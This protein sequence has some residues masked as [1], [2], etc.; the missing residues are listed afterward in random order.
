MKTILWVKE[1]R[2]IWYVVLGSAFIGLGISLFINQQKLY[3]GGINGLTQL[4]VNI[5][6]LIS[7]GEIV[8][9]LGI[10]AFVL[11]MPLI[12]FG[13]FK[14]SKKFILYT[15]VSVALISLFLAIPF[16][17]SLFP[18]DKIT[19]TLIGGILI[20]FG[21]G[22]ILKVGAS[23]GG[24]SIISQYLNIKTGRTVGTYQLIFNGTIIF[25]AGLI[26]GIEIALYTIISHIITS[27]VIDKVHTG[28][29]YMEVQIVSEK[30]EEIADALKG[31]MIHGITVME[32]VGWYT[33][34]NKKVIFTVISVHEIEEYVKLI[35]SIDESAFVIMDGVHRIVGKFVKKLIQ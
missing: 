19:A 16:G 24:I 8:V 10:F 13:Y 5:I 6:E 28:Y 18:Q 34:K 7:G 35:M 21:N 29:N 23:S 20:G 30:G 12:V 31:R 27:L 4:I 33:Q 2:T 25:V 22:L 26:F 3:V 15:L 1:S 32:A 14:L 17:L 11:Q 9:N